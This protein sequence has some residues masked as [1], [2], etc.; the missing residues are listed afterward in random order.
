MR[1]KVAVRTS[2]PR[3]NK[4][5]F[6]SSGDVRLNSRF[7]LQCLAFLRWWRQF[8]FALSDCCLDPPTA[9]CG[10]RRDLTHYASMH[11]PIH[12]ILFFPLSNFHFF[13]QTL[14]RHCFPFTFL[15]QLNVATS[16]QT[17]VL[18]E[19]GFTKTPT[20][21]VKAKQASIHTE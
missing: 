19:L 10:R 14:C 2:L 13:L 12:R 17:T 21:L 1:R 18:R 4:F 8:F 16:I 5:L 3:Q 15:L 7:K 6:D 20:H 9:C 11:V